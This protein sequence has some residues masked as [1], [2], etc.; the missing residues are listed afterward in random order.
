VGQE[1][2]RERERDE[3]AVTFLDQLRPVLRGIGPLGL[4]LAFPTAILVRAD[5]VIQ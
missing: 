2:C 3:S 4:G 5:E 1:F